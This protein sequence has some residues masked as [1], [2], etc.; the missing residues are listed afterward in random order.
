MASWS[1]LECS[2]ACHAGDRGFKSHRGRLKNGV[3]RKS[4]KRR[5]SNLRDCGFDSRPRHL[6]TCVG[7]ASVSLTDCKSAAFGCAGSTPARRTDNMA[8]S[9]IGLGRQPLTLARRVRFPHGLLNGQVAQLED[10]RR[11]ERR[12]R[13][14]LGV[15]ISPWSLTYC[16][17]GRCPTGSHKAGAP[18]SIPGPATCG[19]AQAQPGLI[20]LDRGVQLPDPP[21]M[22]GYANWHSG[23]VES[24]VP[25]GSIPTSV[26]ELGTRSRGPKAKTPG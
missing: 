23:E 26:T 9:S 18:G 5:S 14:G 10:A 16:R 24:L 4:A 17:R 3:V 1:S 15:Q 19:W 8:R 22:T 6:K 7:W 25:V 21:L 20:S 12:A 2:P 13:K 11:S